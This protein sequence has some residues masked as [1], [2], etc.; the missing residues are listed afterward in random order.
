MSTGYRVVVSSHVRKQMMRLERAD[1]CRIAAALDLLA[2]EP[3]PP[4]CVAI[5]GI[6][7]IYRVRVG[8]YRIVYSV[9]DEVRVVAIVRIGHRRDV[10]RR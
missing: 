5:T 8:N 7:S 4:K 1:Q 9:H 6:D 10:Y 2:R 3:R